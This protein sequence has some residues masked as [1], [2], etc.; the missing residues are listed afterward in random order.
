MNKRVQFHCII[1]ACVALLMFGFS[2]AISPLYNKFCKITG[3][4]TALTE[5]EFYQKSDLTRDITVQLVATT[6]QELPW[7]FFPRKTTVLVHPN[8]QIQ[9]YFHAK[10]SAKKRM[11]VQAIPSFSPGISGAH[12][13]KIECFCFTQQTLKAGEE[14]EMPIVF[15]IDRDLPRDIK[16]IT[17]A[18]TLFEIK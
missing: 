9:I 15:K 4:N 5:K 7:D 11:T 10:N 14:K 17:L 1:L 16:T 18:Y 13:H 8:E 2:F 6:N 12:F 3:I